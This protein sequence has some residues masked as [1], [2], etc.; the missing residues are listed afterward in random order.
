MSVIQ[1]A[2]RPHPRLWMS[3]V[4]SICVVYAGISIAQAGEISTS[5]Q[6]DRFDPPA[7]TAPLFTYP[8]ISAQ[9]P[10]PSLQADDAVQTTGSMPASGRIAAE[11]MPGRQHPA[12]REGAPLGS[13]RATWYQHPGRTASGERYNPDGFT[14]AHATLPFGSRVRVVNRTNNRSVVVRITDRTNERTKAKRNYVIDLSR[15]S[16]RALGIEGIGRVA[17]YRAD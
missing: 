3:L 1:R 10:P 12:R 7:R 5:S 4:A 6:D 16:A 13:G 2:D 8:Q 17:L 14:A 15:G 11:T 9:L